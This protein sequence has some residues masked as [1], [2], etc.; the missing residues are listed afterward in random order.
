[1]WN[2]LNGSLLVANALD[3]SGP[4]DVS[5]VLS[6]DRYFLESCRLFACKSLRSGNSVASVPNRQYS[7]APY[8]NGQIQPHGQPIGRF[9]CRLVIFRTASRS[10]ASGALSYP[11]MGFVP[12]FF[13]SSSHPLHVFLSSRRWLAPKLAHYSGRDSIESLS[14]ASRQFSEQPAG[15]L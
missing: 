13:S 8:P 9:S 4:A 7:T 14:L 3:W 10:V 2:P 15:R 1:M 12:L 5:L 6:M 11:K